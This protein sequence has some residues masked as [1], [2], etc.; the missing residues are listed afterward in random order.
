MRT[1]EYQC[2]KCGERQDVVGSVHDDSPAPIH[3]EQS[4][5]WAPTEVPMGRFR[6]DP[7]KAGRDTGVYEYDW[8]VR[9]TW[10]LTVPG[11][12]KRL[13]RS[14]RIARDPFDEFDEKV[15]KGEVP[16][17]KAK[18]EATSGEEAF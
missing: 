9:A 10:D 2:G 12:M 16:R 15:K 7:S 5:D 8:G 14:G 1:I 18:R 6:Y 4:M 13:E 3:C 11:K 17:Y